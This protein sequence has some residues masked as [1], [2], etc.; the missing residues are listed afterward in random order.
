MI[1]GISVDGLHAID[2]ATYISTHPDSALAHLAGTGITYPNASTSEPSDSFPGLLAEVTGGTP[3]STGVYYDD[4]YDR[5]L[6]APGS[7]CSVHGTETLYDESIDRNSDLIDG[8]GGINPAALPR[9][10]AH[11]CA[12]STRTASCV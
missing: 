5:S 7:N 6:A 3:R 12:R 1:L 4:S 11:G 8:G 2:L 10:P 9:D